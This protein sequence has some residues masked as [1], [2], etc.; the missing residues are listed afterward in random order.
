VASVRRRRG[1]PEDGHFVETFLVEPWLEHL[2]QHER[3]TK[4]DRALQDAVSWFQMPTAP[5][6]SHFVAVDPS[7]ARAAMRGRT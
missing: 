4:D 5:K 7:E 2:R 6:V 1:R 3:V